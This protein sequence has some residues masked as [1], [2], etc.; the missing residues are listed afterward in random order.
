MCEFKIKRCPNCGNKSLT[1]I[2]DEWVCYECEYHS[3]KLMKKME[4]SFR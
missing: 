4:A 2:L 1:K 3:K